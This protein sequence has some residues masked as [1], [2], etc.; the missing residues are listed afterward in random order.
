MSEHLKPSW[1]WTM[2][3]EDF[4]RCPDRRAISD[5]DI[6]VPM[7]TFPFPAGGWVLSS[8]LTDPHAFPLY[9]TIFSL[10]QRIQSLLWCGSLL[11]GCRET[12]IQSGFISVWLKRGN[13]V[14]GRWDDVLSLGNK[15]ESRLKWNSYS[16]DTGFKSFLLKKWWRLKPKTKL[17]VNVFPCLYS[18]VNL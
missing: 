7:T 17:T 9:M 14:G 16:D 6:T 12:S 8:V 2:V 11:D 10:I 15:W 5:D 13:F 1:K 3:Y 4:D 18:F